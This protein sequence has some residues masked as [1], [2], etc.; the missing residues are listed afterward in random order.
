MANM[1]KEMWGFLDGD[2]PLDVARTAMEGNVTMREARALLVQEYPG[3]EVIFKRVDPLMVFFDGE[4][5]GNM[6]QIAAFQRITV[7]EAKA[8][9]IQRN[10]GREV[11]F[12]TF[13]RKV[14][15]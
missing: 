5:M 10:P 9:I 12:K 15:K 3:R 6:Y 7:E 8:L 14:I 11:T 1:R 4:Q 2:K 13:L